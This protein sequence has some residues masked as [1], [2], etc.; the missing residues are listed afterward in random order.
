MAVCVDLPSPVAG[1]DPSL[2]MDGYHYDPALAQRAV[3]FFPELL[4][5][6]KNSRFTKANDAF[7]LEPWQDSIIRMLFGI[8]DD[9][10]LR[11]FRTAYIEIPRKNGKTTLSAGIAAYGLFADQEAG[12]ECYCA[13]ATR[14]Q[15]G[16]LF[17]VLSGMISK[18]EVLANACKVR[19][20]VKRIIY[21]DSY[22]RAVSS[23]AHSLHGLNSHI[24]VADEVHAWTGGGHDL[25]DVLSTGCASRAQPIMI[26]IT[27]AGHD[28]TSK[29]Y[30]LHT[31]A[32]SVRDGTI[33]DPSFLPI[34]FG[35]EPGDDWKDPE[36]WAKANPNLGVSIP[37]EYLK[38][39]CDQAI[40]NQSFQNSFRRL[41]L[42]QW[43]AQRNR[44]LNMDAWRACLDSDTV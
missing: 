25:W 34:V 37:I 24:V 27:T 26:A 13:A 43:T 3:D 36:V 14:D 32:K 31:Y 35:A 19:K 17:E 1:F 30:E 10:N 20:S 22:L 21:G 4:R 40:Q 12:A 39:V 23:D 15:A 8:V 41:H 16:L 28:Q 29:C 33:D 44:W 7:R 9:N 42:N 18:S 11:R 5:H 2:L 6:T 38:Q